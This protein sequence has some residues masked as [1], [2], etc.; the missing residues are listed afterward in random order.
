V[1]RS[2][3]KDD[4][5]HFIDKWEREKRKRAN[6]DDAIARAQRP[7]SEANEEVRSKYAREALERESELLASTITGRRNDQLNTSALK[8]GQLVGA[9]YLDR[10]EVESALESACQANGYI[11]DDGR[12]SFR[13]SLK[14]G[15]EDGIASPRD[16]SDVGTHG[17]S[18][19]VAIGVPAR[20]KSQHLAEIEGDFWTRRESLATVYLAAMNGLLSPWA[21]LGCCAAKA[22]TLCPP[23][24]R[25]PALI[26]ISPGSLNWFCI[27]AGRSGFGK[28]VTMA[29]VDEL[30]PSTVIQ[31][32]IGSGEGMTEAYRRPRTDEEPGNYESIMFIADEIDT[33]AA[34]KSRTGSTTMTM[35]RS[36]FSGATLGASTKASSN[37]HVPAQSYRMTLVVGA[38]PGRVGALMDDAD[39]GTPQRFMWFP[40][41]DDRVNGE[42]VMV[43][44]ELDVPTQ[45]T[46]H[47]L[48][49]GTEVQVPDVVVRAVKRN[50]VAVHKGQGSEMDSHRLFVREKFAFALA[51]LDGRDDMSEEDWE[52]AGVAM[53]VSD[54]TRDWV[55][56][57]QEDVER[58][59][60]EKLGRT[61]GM[62]A[63]AAEKEK[64]ASAQMD[65]NRIAT[66]LLKYIKEAG[67]QGITQGDMHRKLPARDRGAMISALTLL[68][69]S[70]VAMKLDR[71][72]RPFDARAKDEHDDE[73]F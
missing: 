56:A 68:E 33:L 60:A 48:R 52:L 6:A 19:Y 8:L 9:G 38:Q 15:L 13:A 1:P 45:L 26:G 17:H 49:Y 63:A 54:F 55:V 23:T 50:R 43:P 21:L 3:N 62:V 53:S 28:T 73:P 61:S 14:S 34:H 20:I 2:N 59:E 12:R 11:K 36:A 70:D 22:L 35:L 39:A 30:I 7:R 65:T 66:L 18:E 27:L 42:E 57:S 46:S 4:D 72:W 64:A 44:G 5:E 25:L 67:A 41:L 29:A 69:N 71:K 32:N 24:V 47:T 40:V 31:R 16:M 10:L 58:E 51:L 37:F